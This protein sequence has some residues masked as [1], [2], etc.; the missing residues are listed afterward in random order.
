MQGSGRIFFTIVPKIS[1]LF[2]LHRGFRQVW[3]CRQAEHTQN[4]DL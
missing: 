2:P 3:A 1:T 4:E